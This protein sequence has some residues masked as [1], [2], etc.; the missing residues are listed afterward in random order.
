MPHLIELET[1]EQR[2]LLQKLFYDENMKVGRDRMYKYCRTHHPYLNLNR[3]QVGEWLMRQEIWQR[4][5][6]PIR[7]R[8]S[9]KSVVKE[10]TNIGYFQIDLKY[11]P[12]PTGRVHLYLIV[13]I[14]VFSRLVHIAFLEDKSQPSVIARLKSVIED[15]VWLSKSGAVSHVQTDRGTQFSGAFTNM[16]ADKEITSS[17]SKAIT[18]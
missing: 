18:L 6:K 9:T 3:L 7:R 2:Q 4:T 13:V 16:L 10:K 14:D 8:S 12:F 5:L 17:R 15:S 1:D 11:A